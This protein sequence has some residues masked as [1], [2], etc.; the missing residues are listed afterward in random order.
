MS[1]CRYCGSE[2]H[3]D[4][5][6]TKKFDRKMHLVGKDDRSALCKALPSFVLPL[7]LTTD[8]SL[9]N[10]SRCQAHAAKLGLTT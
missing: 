3:R 2:N 4:Q 10:C 1:G 5:F 7:P 8:L 9:V 6:C